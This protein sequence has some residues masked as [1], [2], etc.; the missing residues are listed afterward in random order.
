MPVLMT[1][2]RP[3]RATGPRIA[4]LVA[5]LPAADDAGRAALTAAFWS[6]V[7]GV[8]TPLVEEAA[9]APEHRVVTFLW[10]GHRATRQVL[11]CGN[12]LVDREQL[13]GA[14][15][16]RVPGTD[17]WHLGL[18]LRAD[19]RGSYRLAADIS[20]KEPPTDPAGLQ[21]RLRS[22]SVHAAADPLNPR[23]IARRWQRSDSSVFALPDAPG[24]AV[25][26]AA[27]GEDGAAG[28]RVER[29]P[30]PT[31]AL[32]GRRDTWVYLPPG[33]PR[34]E[35]PPP[36]VLV[37][38]DGDMWFGRLRLER[39]LDALIAD[40]S[41]PPL[42][43]LAPDAVDRLTRR[44][45]LGG[46]DAFVTFLA[47]ELLPW[48]RGRRPLTADPA[49]TVVAGQRLGAVTALYAAL[50]RPDHFGAVL[51]QSAALSW[52]PGESGE[53]PLAEAPWPVTRS[54]AVPPLPVR[55]HLD[56]GLQEGPVLD[57]H[58]TLYE[59]L[60]TAGN[61]VTYTEFNGG[62]DYAC[63]EVALGR[64]LVGLLGGAT[65]GTTGATGGSAGRD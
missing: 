9:G 46:R 39:T 55:V 25:A 35:G 6:E 23:R 52:R 59:T 24:P 58:R 62:H 50:R 22:L 13:A 36:P 63:W 47:G 53:P 3:V 41:L 21:L 42:A 61:Q 8:G 40:G 14:L 15:L 1:V 33:H 51:V 65:D 49:R 7:E 56:V 20:A 31:E 48:A 27:R 43:V 18:R 19:H 57:R 32:G 37:L 11:L 34:G 44:R 2:P 10:R 29:C 16:E 60:R 26:S 5:E 64:A 30:V 28:G 17:V 4:R 12:R 54:A 38:T 45:E